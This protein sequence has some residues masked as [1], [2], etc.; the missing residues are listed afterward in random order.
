MTARPSRAGVRKGRRWMRIAV[1]PGQLRKELARLLHRIIVEGEVPAQAVTVLTPR[2][3]TNSQVGGTVGR[4]ELV[5]N[6]TRP[7]DVRL[8]S[9]YRFKGLDAPAIVVCEVGRD[10]E[11]P[12]M[13]RLMYVAC[14]RARTS[15]SLLVDAK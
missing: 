3:V 8:A 15:L 13:R 1:A 5:E 9:V 2:S 10:L 7:T 6:P 4:F 14:S 12:E 11:D